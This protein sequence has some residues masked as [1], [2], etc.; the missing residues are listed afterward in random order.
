VTVSAQALDPAK[1]GT[2]SA[3]ISIRPITNL[4]GLSQVQALQHEV[5]MPESDLEII[6]THLLKA[7]ATQGGVLLGAFNPKGDAVGFVFGFLARHHGAYGHHSHM[8]GVLPAYQNSG[9]GRQLKLAQREAVM[10]QGLDTIAW[11]YDPLEGRNAHLNINKLG[12]VCRTYVQDMYGELVDGLNQGLPSDRFLV[13][14]QLRSQRVIERLGEPVAA[15]TMDGVLAE[16]A[17]VV[18]GS[19]ATG[20][21]PPAGPSPLCKDCSIALVQIPS[22]FQ[23]LREDDPPAALEWRMQTRSVFESLFADGFL[24]TGLVRTLREG[25]PK[26]YY[27]LER[28]STD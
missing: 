6:P 4:A 28:T 3:G 1:V 14:W 16:G 23:R 21:S 19:L 5:W 11:T 10:A 20:G 7:V 13:E 22:D 12:S 24:V 25:Y 9:V 18:D 8:M 26:T 2:V 27:L 15:P 17:V